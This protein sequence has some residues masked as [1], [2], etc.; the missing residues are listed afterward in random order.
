[1]IPLIG[2]IGGRESDEQALHM[3]YETG[4][5]IARYEYG[6]VCGGKGGIMESAA[7]GCKEQQGWTV[8]IIP[9][10]DNSTANPFIDIVI[11]TGM[12]IMRNALV[13]RSARGL[14]AIDGQ[15]GTLS[16][17]AFALQMHKP[18]VGINTWDVSET[19]VQAKEGREAIQK[20]I[21]MIQ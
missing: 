18:V 4:Q 3:A 15:Y 5:W 11:P 16:E 17:L 13:V 7:R 1:M 6:L 20:L 9:E 10:E 8:G 14:I 21:G 12:G 19:I 2:V